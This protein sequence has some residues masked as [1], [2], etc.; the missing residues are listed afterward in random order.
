[1]KPFTATVLECHTSTNYALTYFKGSSTC[2]F[3]SFVNKQYICN[4]NI[5]RQDFR[6]SS[7]TPG[8]SQKYFFSE[9]LPLLP[10]LRTIE[11]P[12]IVITY[13]C[14][15]RYANNYVQL[16]ATSCVF[17]MN[18]PKLRKPT[19]DATNYC[20]QYVTTSGIGFQEAITLLT[21]KTTY[22]GIDAYF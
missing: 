21:G 4:A 12:L 15:Q 14:S 19:L 8:M 20:Q 13:T 6:G 16:F 10:I 9:F 5:R 2:T 7:T 17:S 18:A 3:D 22:Q 1:M 11:L